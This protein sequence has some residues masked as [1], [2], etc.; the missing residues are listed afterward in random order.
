MG[1]V[2]QRSVWAMAAFRVW[3]EGVVR[4]PIAVS[5]ILG[6][7]FILISHI[8]ASH[9]APSVKI[10]TGTQTVRGEAWRPARR[11]LHQIRY[12]SNRDLTA[13]AAGPLRSRY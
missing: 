13:P 2:R 5:S 10:D 3:I 11:S 12:R 6:I 8:G 9:A 4:Y 1:L 7:A